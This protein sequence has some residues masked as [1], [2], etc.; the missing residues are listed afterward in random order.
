MRL[1]LSAAAAEAWAMW[2]ADRAILLPL[3]GLLLFVPSLA[4]ILFLPDVPA[5]PPTGAGVD[6]MRAFNAAIIAWFRGN[7]LLL[8]PVLLVSSFGQFAVLSFYLGRHDGTLAQA[9]V[10]ALALLPRYL[11][12]MVVSGGMVFGGLLLFIL[13]GFYLAG[14]TLMVGAVIAAEPLP[15]LRGVERS[16]TI[17]RRQGFTLAG[18]WLLAVAA[19]QLLGQPMLLAEQALR[20]GGAANPVAIVALNLLAAAVSAGVAL[21]FTLYQVA[22]YRQLAAAR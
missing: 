9:L 8:A 16:F 13:P 2:R 14:R 10:R 4:M 11:L 18:V 15:A 1:D 20:A 17:T 6:E 19:A 22:L 3:A 5:R 21:A 12:A 7:V